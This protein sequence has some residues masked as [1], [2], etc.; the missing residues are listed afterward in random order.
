ME[1]ADKHGYAVWHNF[2]NIGEYHDLY[3]R[4]VMLLLAYVL[5]R[6]HNK[7]IKINEVDPAHFLEAP[8]LLG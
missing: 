1:A 4:S 8:A 7:C 5:R 2:A 6:F 3:A